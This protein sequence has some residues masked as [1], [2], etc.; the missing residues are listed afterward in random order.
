[1]NL[2][3]I[4][5]LIGVALALIIAIVGWVSARNTALHIEARALASMKVDIAKLSKD[6]EWIQKCK[7]CPRK[8]TGGEAGS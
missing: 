1:L 2:E 8:G 6:V 4:L 7:D 3:N 5:T